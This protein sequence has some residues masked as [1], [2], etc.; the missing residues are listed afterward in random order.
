M[1]IAIIGSGVV[2]LAIGIAALQSLKAGVTVFDKEVRAGSHAST[3]NSGVIHSGIYYSG[4]SLKAKFSVAGNIMLKELCEKHRVRVLNTG[5]LIL[6]SSFDDEVE[7]EKLMSR[8]TANGVRATRMH[9]RHLDSYEPKAETLDSFI[10]VESTAVAD[11]RA[12]HEALLKEFIEMGGQLRLDQKIIGTTVNAPIALGGST[13]DYL[14]NAAGSGALEI[15]QSLGVGTDFFSTPFLG[16]YYETEDPRA[17]VKMP[18]YPVPH[19]INPFLGVHLTPSLSGS[20]KIGPSAIPVLGREQYS[21]FKGVSLRDSITASA[22]FLRIVRG[23]HHNFSQIIRSEL[24]KF[25]LRFMVGQASALAPGLKD[26]RSWKPH[27]A[28]IRSQLVSRDGE[29][30]QD[31]L[32]E[33]KGDSLHILNAVSP[34]WTSSLAFGEW[35]FRKFIEKRL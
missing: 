27:A 26:V 11:P 35:I 5:K 31:F 15:A 8:A 10:H 3:R 32:V 1:R 18:L 33:E 6:S 24:P 21:A 4:D 19:K 28:G 17:R 7:L 29:L 22:A 23:K 16:V 25:S 14:I 34:G 2:G 20:T 30:V 13:F 12:V 9:K